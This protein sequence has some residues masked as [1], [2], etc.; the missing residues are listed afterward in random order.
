MCHEIDLARVS[1]LMTEELGKLLKH[2][3]ADRLVFGS[4]MPFDYPDPAVLNMEFLVASDDERERIRWR[5]AVRL[6]R[7]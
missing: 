2:L 5:N 1:P 7:L 4:G 6:L 3:G